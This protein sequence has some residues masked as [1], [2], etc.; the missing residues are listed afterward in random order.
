MLCKHPL[1][2]KWPSFCFLQKRSAVERNQGKK[3]GLSMKYYDLILST[4]I[5]TVLSLSPAALAA[6]QVVE[7]DATQ[8]KL[9]GNYFNYMN[10]PTF[11]DS[12]GG[13]INHLITLAYEFQAGTSLAG[14]FRPDTHI[15]N[16][17]ELLTM[18]DSFLK[19]SQGL[20]SGALNVSGQ[21]R[22]YAPISQ[23]S[24]DQKLIGTFQP[25]VYVGSSLG[26]LD[27]LYV[28]I[29]KI[30]AVSETIPNQLS[31]AHGHLLASNYHLSDSFSLDVS[32]YPAFSK[33]TGEQLVFNKIDTDIGFTAKLAKNLAISPYV[34]F[35]LTEPK[36]STT[37]A[38]ANLDY[39]FF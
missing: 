25:R 38:A 5:A 7:A 24:Q 17:K 13:S 12:E 15:G 9:S 26:N 10:G 34:E 27:L 39:T 2:K 19:F 31:F 18:G 3:E 32:A 33:K 36:L 28:L 16:D 20:S 37:Y 4:V 22:Y 14:V 11:Q 6:D 30:Y 29:P 35:K 1:P 23:A 21:L 8:S